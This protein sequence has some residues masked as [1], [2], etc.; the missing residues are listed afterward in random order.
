MMMMANPAE[1][2]RLQHLASVSDQFSTT[3]FMQQV[4]TSPHLR[5]G[6]GGAGGVVHRPSIPGYN[7]KPTPATLPSR[8]KIQLIAVLDGRQ[9]MRIP[10]TVRA[11][12]MFEMASVT[13]RS[14]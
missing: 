13:S 7:S 4:V 8:R 6:P 14:V 11:P 3:R 9:P 5:K 10:M 12:C 1:Q 2:Q